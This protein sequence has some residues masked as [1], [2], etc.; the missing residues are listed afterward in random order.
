MS[1]HPIVLKSL[2]AAEARIDNLE[3]WQDAQNGHLARIDARLNLFLWFLVGIFA[4]SAGSLLALILS[5][6][7]Q[8]L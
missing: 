3:K 4:P 8:K 6:L 7:I 5:L 2:G 1:T